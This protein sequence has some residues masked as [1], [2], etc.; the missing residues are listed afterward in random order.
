MTDYNL[1]SP[2]SK[3]W[4]YQSNLRFTD[5]EIEEIDTQIKNFVTQWVSHNNAL[6]AYGKL[7]LN[8]FI[9][10]MVDESQAGASGC[11]IDK[12][13]HFIKAMGFHH[14]VDFFDRMNFAYKIGE[15]L[16][17]AHRDKFANLYQNG[18]IN[19]ST[20]VYNNLVKDKKEFENSWVIPLKN[21]W[22]ARMV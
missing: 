10:L 22:H 17:T 5:E 21:S 1:M 16:Q 15:E 12:S 14:G 20:L 13:V 9:I 7:Y 3:V 8:R 19:D 11:S 6:K 2:D 4:I 18:E